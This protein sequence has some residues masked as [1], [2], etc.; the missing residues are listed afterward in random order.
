ME[1][2]RIS[3][4]PSSKSVKSSSRWRHKQWVLPVIA[5]ILSAPQSFAAAPSV[6][7]DAQ[8]TM[9]SGLSSP[10]GVAVAPN[11]TI[12]VAD[13]G[14]SRI[15]QI[16]PNLPGTSA[17]T[18][19]SIPQLNFPWSV[20]VDS[21]GDLYVGDISTSGNGRIFE[22]VANSS[23]AI[24]SS[25]TVKTLYSGTAFNIP[26]SLTVGS[27]NTLFIGGYSFSGG[28]GIY[29]IPSGGTIHSLTFSGLSGTFFPAGLAVSGSNLYLADGSS[30]SNGVYVAPVNGGAAKPVLEG[31]FTTT[32]PEGLGIDSAGDLYVLAQLSGGSNEQ[33]VVIPNASA[34]NQSS[35]YIVPSN[36]LTNSN[37]LAVDSQG[38]VDLVGSNTSV[39]QLNFVNPVYLGEATV[40]QNGTAITFN[41]EFNAPVN[42]TGLRAITVGD[43]GSS[44]D[45]VQVTGGAGGNCAARNLTGQTATNPYTCYRQFETTPQYVGTRASSIQVLGPGAAVLDSN[46]VYGLGDAA[47]QVAY[48]LD[49]TMTQLG[50]IQP[51]GITVSGFDKTVYIADFAGAQVYSISGLNGSKTSVVSTGSIALSAPSAVAMNGEGDLYIADFNLGEVVVVPTTTGVAPYVLNAGGLLQHPIALALDALGDL[52][53]G[54]AGSG[55]ESASSSNPGFVVEVPYSGTAFQLATNGV[56]IV[57]PQAL[58]LNNIN[59]V[60]AIGDGGDANTLGQVVEL[61]ASGAASVVSITNPAPTTDPSGLSFDAAGNLYVLDGVN[62]TITEVYTNGNTALLP[63]STPLALSGPSAMA[64]SAGSQSFVVANLGG[65][66]ANSLIY[67]NGNSST[68]A[69]GNQAVNT[70]SASQSVTVANIGNQTLTLNN[71]YYSPRPVTGFPLANGTCA[72]NDS[73]TSLRSCTL[74]FQFAPTTATAYSKAATV[75]SNAYNSGTPVISLTGTGTAKTQSNVV[76]PF[77]AHRT[78]HVGRKSFALVR[79]R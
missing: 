76:T 5:I 64:S 77:A 7:V 58:A 57:F 48:P 12:Y 17:Q 71:G 73:Y 72:G 55:G 23:G 46:P 9:G 19:V 14:A 16:I 68:L 67:L 25:S 30:G 29:T 40:Y 37:A 74:A 34:V 45:V 18:T 62:N 60:L 79:P 78:N 35:P 49:T 51:Q 13:T 28:G 41:F 22:V 44:N 24:T 54:D 53:I 10:E 32:Q 1:S 27:S 56:S 69:F 26:L 65:G 43:L 2:T 52:Y 59:G 33:V 61:T 63:I 66:T 20:A 3:S 11:G 36:N 39:T 21:A 6:V 15:V 38:N 42:F 75:N 31:S 8:Q 70:V 50:L 47:A 4:V